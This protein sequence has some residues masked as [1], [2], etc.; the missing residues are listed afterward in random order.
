MRTISEFVGM[1]VLELVGCG[2]GAVAGLSLAT[3]LPFVEVLRRLAEEV[4]R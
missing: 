2:L 3:N 1:A 4:T